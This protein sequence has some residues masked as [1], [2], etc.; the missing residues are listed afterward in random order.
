M[1][2]EEGYEDAL[3]IK[4]TGARYIKALNKKGEIIEVREV[5]D[6]YSLEENEFES[7]FEEYKL[8]QEN[9]LGKYLKKKIKQNENKYKLNKKPLRASNPLYILPID[10]YEQNAEEFYKNQPFFYDKQKIFWLWNKEHNMFEMVDDIEI[11]RKLDSVLGFKGQTIDPKIKA[12]YLEAIKWVGRDK[13]PPEA[14]VKWVQ[15]KNKA[16][17]LT[18]GKIHNV[19]PDYFFTNPIPWDMGKT[20]ETPIMDELIKSWVGE[21]QL[22][23]IYEIIAYCCFRG[24]PIHRWF[25][26]L[27]SGCN[28]KS[29]LMN[30]MQKFLGENNFCSNELDNLTT[31]RFSSFG[32]YKKSA[33]FMGET[34]LNAM[35][36]TTILKNLTAEDP[37]SFER[38]GKDVKTDKNYAK[39]IVASNSLPQTLDKTDGFYRRFLHLEF[40]NTFTGKR[41]VLAEIPE[42]EYNNLALKV[43]NILKKLLEKREFDNELSVKKKKE[44]Y[45]GFSNPLIIYLKEHYVNDLDGYIFNYEFKNSFNAWCVE[46]GH[47]PRMANEINQYMK[48]YYNEVRR[49]AEFGDGGA[50]R[51]WKGLCKKE[52]KDIEET[53]TTEKTDQ[54]NSTPLYIL[55]NSKRLVKSVDWVDE[56][57]EEEQIKLEFDNKLIT[58][59]KCEV[60]GCT[61]HET[62]QDSNGVHYCRKHWEEMAQ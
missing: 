35:K 33:C 24:Y 22:K 57:V 54:L 3:E 41:D 53:Q 48:E 58:Y 5:G 20:T 49:S 8:D 23:C 14:P 19:T 29:T 26:F 18:S 61:E 55:S 59:H 45:E 15:F 42:Y 25:C 27:G 62:N 7:D 60:E 16:Y 17:S 4:D 37:I 38:K 31:N 43:C 28:G 6:T 40:N 44:F 9:A 50:I 52:A 47:R 36:S 12:S 10:N 39:I 11:R 56:K 34:N 46:N 51:A 21:E 1:Q 13:Q 2:I 32:L 30:L